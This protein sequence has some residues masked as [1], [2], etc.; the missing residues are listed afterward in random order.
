MEPMRIKVDVEEIPVILEK[1]D[2]TEMECTLRGLTG[3]GRDKY[4][5]SMQ[6]KIR[7]GSSGRPIGMKSFD[8]LYAGLLAMCLF[9]AENE[10]IPL[11]DIQAFSATCQGELFAK[12][13]KI[14]SLGED[15][16]VDSKND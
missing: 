11:A 10:L 8:G 5:S 2:G 7:Y 13:Q 6:S 14:S 3:K 9:D 15:A 4:L 12:A 1:A 16:E